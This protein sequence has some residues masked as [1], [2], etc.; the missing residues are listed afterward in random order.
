MWALDKKKEN[1]S[2]TTRKGVLRGITRVNKE[3][4]ILTTPVGTLREQTP[5]KKDTRDT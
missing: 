3:E 5:P 1:L 4:V 2:V